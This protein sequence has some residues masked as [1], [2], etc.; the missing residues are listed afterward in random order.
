[1]EFTPK[2][3]TLELE[4][5]E[6]TLFKVYMWTQ[7]TIFL[8]V[9]SALFWDTFISFYSAFDG[10]VKRESPRTLRR[11]FLHKGHI[12]WSV[13]PKRWLILSCFMLFGNVSMIHPSYIIVD[14]IRETV[15]RIQRVHDLVDVTLPVIHQY[16]GI[17]YTE[18]KSQSMV[19]PKYADQ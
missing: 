11:R 12:P 16:Q 13:Y 8:M 5:T 10:Q 4:T 9:C 19:E 6:L 14:S 17:R 1:M 7:F 18:W 2:S 15:S 3:S